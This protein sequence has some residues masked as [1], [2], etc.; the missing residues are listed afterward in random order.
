[1]TRTDLCKFFGI[2]KDTSFRWQRE[3]LP[4]EKKYISGSA[5][6]WDFDLVKTKEWFET[7]KKGNK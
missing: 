7:K 4:K 3:G 5:W 1:M 2:S 6:R